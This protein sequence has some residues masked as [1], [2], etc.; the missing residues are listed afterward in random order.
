MH[1]N[2]LQHFQRRASAL[3]PL[4]HPAG[5]HDSSIPTSTNVNYI[6]VDV[7]GSRGGIGPIQVS[8]KNYL[9]F[10]NVCKSARSAAR[11][12]SGGWRHCCQ[13]YIVSATWSNVV[14]H[15]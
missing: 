5:A 3:P 10:T 6:V 4:A 14:G 2:T 8:T 13:N 9:L 15:R 12:P 7:V 11:G 1:K